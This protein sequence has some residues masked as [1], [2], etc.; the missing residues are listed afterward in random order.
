MK[1]FAMLLRREYWEHRAAFLKAPL[2]TGATLFTLAVMALVLAAS[3]L[4]KINGTEFVV[5][6]IMEQLSTLDPEQLP[7][8]WS[9]YFLSMTILFNLVLMIVL[10]FYLLGSL[11]DDRKDRSILFWKSLPISDSA[12]VLSKFFTALLIA[13]A[14]MIA[15]LTA[16]NLSMMVVATILIFIGEGSAWDLV[17]SPAAPLSHAATL[18]L[19]YLVHG[20]WMAPVFGWLIFASALARRRPFLVAFLPLGI[21]MVLENWFSIL[22]TFSVSDNFITPFILERFAQGVVP[23]GIIEHSGDGIM[24]HSYTGTDL[25][26]ATADL[27]E[28]FSKVGES[29][30]WIGLIIAA[31]LL[32]GAIILRRL[33][34]ENG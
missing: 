25:D 1:S 22:R 33:R 11:H 34:D 26:L 13:P 23:L 7:V 21:I 16:T 3:G 29:D 2:F 27:Q 20:L 30:F 24:S 28:I 10:L 5:Q 19:A 15:M 9:R 6:S 14:L 8:I 4:A 17:W 32:G 31:A 18:C 12:T